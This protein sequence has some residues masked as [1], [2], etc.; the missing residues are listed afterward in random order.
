MSE[1]T[2]FEGVAKITADTTELDNAIAKIRTTIKNLSDATKSA[3]IKSGWTNQLN[4]IKSSL[5]G[6]NENTVTNAGRF[7][8]ALTKLSG[9]GNITISTSIG[10]QIENIKNSLTGIDPS[11][12]GTMQIVADSLG[13]L[14]SVGDIKISS[15][16]GTQL[17]KIFSAVNGVSVEDMDKLTNISQFLGN[18]AFVGD[19]KLS[20]S[21]ANQIKAIASATR[22]MQ[23]VDWTPLQELTSIIERMSNASAGARDNM[24]GVAQSIK[25]INNA[26]QHVGNNFLR[27]GLLLTSFVASIKAVFYTGR[28]VLSWAMNMIQESNKY[29]EDL[30][31]FT[32]TMGEYASEAL[33]YANKVGSVMGIDPAE[34][35]RYQG[36]FNTLLEG[37]GVASDRASIMSQNLTQLGYDLASFYNIDYSESMDKLQS[38]L[39]GQIKGVRTLGYDISDVKLQEIALANGIDKVTD[40]MNQSEKAQLRYIALMTQ[41]TVVQN[42]MARTLNAPANQLRVL[43]AQV[44][45]LKRALGNVFIPFLNQILPYVMAVVR[46]LRYVAEAIANLF[47]YKLPEIDYSGITESVSSGIDDVA[48]S[49]D[50]ATASAKELKATILGFDELNVMNSPNSGGSGGSGSGGS[51]GGVDYDLPTYD[52]LKGAV[53][54]KVDAIYK[55]MKPFFDFIVDN[56]ET[57]LKT[58]G[59][60]A[61]GFLAWKLA[62]PFVKGIKALSE[63]VKKMLQSKIGGI[64]LGVVL[65]IT[66]VIFATQGAFGLGYGDL[67][68]GNILKTLLGGA[69]EVAGISLILTKLGLGLSV[70]LP[71]ALVITGVTIV[72]SMIVGAIRKAVDENIKKRFGTIELD[73]EDIEVI[74]R[75]LTLRSETGIKLSAYIDQ[76]EVVEQAGEKLNDAINEFNNLQVRLKAGIDVDKS[77]IESTIDNLINTTSDF[78]KEKRVSLQLGANVLLGG[79]SSLDSVTANINNIYNEYDSQLMALG[80][81][82]KEVVA[83]GFQNGEWIDDYQA[84]AERLIAQINEVTAKVQDHEFTVEMTKLKLQSNLDGYSKETF[85]KLLSSLTETISER[86]DYAFDMLAEQIASGAYETDS[87]IRDAISGY[88]AVTNDA[89]SPAFEIMSEQLQNGFSDMLSKSSDAWKESSSLLSKEIELDPSLADSIIK[90][91][92]T[93]TDAFITGFNQLDY[94][95]QLVAQEMYESLLPT[96]DDYQKVANQYTA[97]GQAVPESVRKGL[98]DAYTLGA[99]SGD[100][101]AINYMLGTHYSTDQSFLHL[102]ATS[103]NA[104]KEVNESIRRGF[105]NSAQY[106]YD[107]ATNT[108]KVLVDGVEQ[109]RI[110]ATPYLLENFNQMGI[111][112]AEETQDGVISYP[113]GFAKDWL[114]SVM[115]N[116]GKSDFYSIDQSTTEVMSAIV[117]G[118]K[119]TDKYVA[120]DKLNDIKTEADTSSIYYMNRDV[121]KLMGDINLTVGNADITYGMKHL[122]NVKTNADL[123]DFWTLGANVGAEIGVAMANV[124]SADTNYGKNHLN[125]VKSNAN[126]SSIFGLAKDILNLVNNIIGKFTNARTD[127]VQSML[128]KSRTSAGS[129]SIFSLPSLI[130]TSVLNPIVSAFSGTILKFGGIDLPSVQGAMVG[131][132][133][134]L[135]ASFQVS[136]YIERYAS[137]GFPNTGELFIARES[138]NELVGRIGS[139]NTVA[140]ND[141]IV[142]GISSGVSRA[143]SEQNSLLAEQNALL[144]ELISKTGSSDGV[145]TSEIISALDRTNTR[146]GRTIV[147]L[148]V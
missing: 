47:G 36:V 61:V 103:E 58:V 19:V 38:A 83:K 144:R 67:S 91:T 22:E 109:S 30:N 100:A 105:A 73:N 5:R 106:V 62:T 89:W 44:T 137:G 72:T 45:L 87:Q 120:R 35:I 101:D 33:A 48:D 17:T 3:S 80:A 111:R 135:G 4:T 92:S 147:S 63:T 6:I 131:A 132:S 75:G 59:L 51:V 53:E 8:E 57:I 128:N 69:S 78:L 117:A 96:L 130:Q 139:R 54:N 26:S 7:A 146:N 20:A 81:E 64:A 31:L 74:V 32:A 143:N 123:S 60:I 15:N 142:E 79:T 43:T 138:G 14:G 97:L 85:D 88:L 116:A 13:K 18:L 121:E 21:I 145:S 41:V 107:S 34:W 16:I 68:V 1:I 12:V 112:I 119:S 37:F 24:T 115:K 114:D 136:S 40:S 55:K 70:A 129:S 95:S 133:A 29:V 148:G 122:D 90:Y 110:Q 10:S 11:M 23:G 76:R 94:E 66:G 126:S 102:L 113:D 108:V 52:F 124:D 141:Q 86:T 28:R 140:N 42:D 93:G 9:I 118:I 56:L 125:A 134:G 77:D 46:G 49:I 127:F 84:E 39:S 27:A 82:L 25:S 104:G 50:N 71:I 98:N 65:T 2:V 99:L